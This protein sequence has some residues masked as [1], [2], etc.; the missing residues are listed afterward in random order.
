MCASSKKKK[1]ETLCL[2]RL[3]ELM[4]LCMCTCDNTFS[5]ILKAVILLGNYWSLCMLDTLALTHT[6]CLA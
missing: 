4:N 2:P 1:K 6:Y 5:N 3:C